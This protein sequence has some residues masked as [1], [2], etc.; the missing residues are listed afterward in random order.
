MYSYGLFAVGFVVV[1]LVSIGF[2][3]CISNYRHRTLRRQVGQQTN[4]IRNPNLTDENIQESKS[5]DE[6][7]NRSSK[8]ETIN[9]HN[10]ALCNSTEFEHCDQPQTKIKTSSP[11]F[12]QSYLDVIGDEYK[13][14][15]GPEKIKS[16]LSDTSSTSNDKKEKTASQNTDYYT[17]YEV[18]SCSF[19]C[20]KRIEDAENST[21]SNSLMDVKSS[22]LNK[23]VE[24]EVNSKKESDAMRTYS[25]LNK[26]DMD[27]CQSYLTTVAP[28]SNLESVIKQEK[29]E[30]KNRHSCP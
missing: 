6:L 24:R 15:S 12:D 25:T 16:Y 13:S 11:L 4:E 2:N 18:A 28:D 9:E 27:Y 19:I 21:T 30:R 14:A 3:I 22:S 7:S 1:L 23:H 17:D 29:H 20:G 5:S 26:S 10:M 8:Y